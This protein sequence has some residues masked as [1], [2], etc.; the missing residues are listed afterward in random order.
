MGRCYGFPVHLLLIFDS[1]KGAG[2][3]EGCQHLLGPLNRTQGD[4]ALTGEEVQ[5]A[6]WRARWRGVRKGSLEE[7]AGRQ[8]LEEEEMSYSRSGRGGFARDSAYVLVPNPVPSSIPLPSWK[9]EAYLANAEPSALS[10]KRT[11]VCSGG[12]RAFP[13]LEVAAG[14]AAEC[15]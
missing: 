10:G 6:G 1:H 12:W 15:S 8:A 4:L 3:R 5:N 13:F 9:G 11:E 14:R 2:R 7:T